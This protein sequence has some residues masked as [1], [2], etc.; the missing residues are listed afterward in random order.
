MEED[1]NMICPACGM[2]TY[3]G[4]LCENCG[5]VDNN[6]EKKMYKSNQW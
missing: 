3:N 6:Y 1:D 4:Y 2:N 5:Y